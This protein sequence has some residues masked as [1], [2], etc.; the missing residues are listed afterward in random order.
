MNTSCGSPKLKSFPTSLRTSGLCRIRSRTAD[1][2]L[3]QRNRV[4]GV[5]GGCNRPSRRTEFVSGLMSAIAQTIIETG[6][7]LPHYEQNENVHADPG[8]HTCRTPT[9]AGY[10]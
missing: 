3:T 10:Q 6:T 7:F 4:P 2:Y 9:A 5:I 1:P 8:L